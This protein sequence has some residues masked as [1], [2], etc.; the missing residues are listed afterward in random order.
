MNM[1]KNNDLRNTLRESYNKYAQ[2]REIIV[3]QDWKITE[4]QN[5][6]ALLD[7]EHKKSLLEIGAGTGHDARFF[8]DQGFE[9]VCIDLSPAMIE[10]CK[11]KGLTAYI[12]DVGDIK[13]PR[14]SFD[15]IYAM[16]SLLHLTKDEFPAV[17]SRIDRL[18]KRNGVAFV[19]V[20]GGYDHE[21]IWEKDSYIPRRFYSFY[22]DKRLEQ[23]VAKVFEVL[24]FN[25]I[26]FE[27]ENPIHFQSLLLRKR[28]Q[29]QKAG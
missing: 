16:N 19:G 11:Q 22:T 20:Y 5:F 3:A 26:F 7:R 4:R 17:L 25:R 1:A 6:L 10:L 24:S 15:A 23:E 9:V 21:G 29:F 14:D 28:S 13:F 12:M 8:Q 18:L 27:P 2:E